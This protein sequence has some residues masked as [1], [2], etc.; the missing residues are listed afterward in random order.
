M[1]LST[2]GQERELL[3]KPSYQ[4][5][6]RYLR[7]VKMH[8]LNVESALAVIE[9]GQ[10][11]R[12]ENR[13]LHDLEGKNNRVEP[14]IAFGLAHSF[15]TGYQK[16]INLR[17]DK[18]IDDSINLHRATQ[19]HHQAE[20]YFNESSPFHKFETVVDG[21]CAIIESGIKYR[22]IIRPYNSPKQGAEDLK[23]ALA[24]F[25]GNSLE[26]RAF[27]PI[28]V[29]M[30]E[31]RGYKQPELLIITNHL[32]EPKNTFGIPDSKY[33]RINQRIRGAQQLF[34]GLR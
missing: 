14:E 30:L 21:L 33:E 3:I 23:G 2:N 8:E 18:Q 4:A 5:I 20:M 19:E 34:S 6:C 11:W 16:G 24:I 25:N 7:A 31:E 12:D 17:I 27:A 22:E 15:E 29:K 13:E 28:V 9:K 10:P 1:I 26:R 32:S